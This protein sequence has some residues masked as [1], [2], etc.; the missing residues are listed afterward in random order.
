LLNITN[1]AYERYAERVMDYDDKTSVQSYVFQN[2]EVITE[3]INKMVEYGKEIY[4]GK[5]RDGANV[6]VVVK[7]LWVL[8]L[9]KKR[10]KVITLYK[11]EMIHGDDDFNRTFV[12]KMMERIEELQSSLER[13]KGCFDVAKESF[14]EE[15]DNN[16]TRI[17]EYQA[18]I[19]Q[20]EECNQTH[21]NE[22]NTWNVAV[23]ENEM[24]IKHA[25]EDLIAKK[26][27]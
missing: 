17:K 22:I 26:I 21:K 1:H 9:D 18:L 5:I 8:L 2:K 27:F 7:D 23:E 10:D 19:K 20:L 13:N 15:I 16:N 6:I 12:D 24:K 11:V 25:V 4:Q 3:R 14:Q